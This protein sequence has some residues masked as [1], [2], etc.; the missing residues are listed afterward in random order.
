MP[1]QTT[2]AENLA[3]YPRSA[4]T[5]QGQI[6][7]ALLRLSGRAPRVKT[8]SDR[9]TA[10]HEAGHAVLQEI[11][12][13]RR[14][15]ATI[16]PDGNTGGYATH[17]RTCP[18][19]PREAKAY[20]RRQATQC[21]AGAAAQRRLGMRFWRAGTADDHAN[22]DRAI[23]AISYDLDERRRIAADSKRRARRYVAQFWPEIRCLANAPIRERTL[24]GTA[25]RR[26]VRAAQSR[27]V[28]RRNA[29][30]AR[31]LVAVWPC[32]HPSP[33]PQPRAPDPAKKQPANPKPTSDSPF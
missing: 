25:I 22:A 18:A 15:K 7:G 16:V 12:G 27:L 30:V 14:K 17:A 20:W 6:G 11:L 28:E 19:D 13:I 3:S 9:T 31:S 1:P 32:K 5:R 24:Y 29:T 26:L 33:S 21:Y 2:F 4:A 10:T 8:R 23:D